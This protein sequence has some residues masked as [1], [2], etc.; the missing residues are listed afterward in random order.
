MVSSRSTCRQ[1]RQAAVSFCSWG[2][3]SSSQRAMQ[4]SQTVQQYLAASGTR[5]G[6]QVN[7]NISEKQASA[8]CMVVMSISRFSVGAL[9]S[10]KMQ[11]SQCSQVLKQADMYRSF[12]IQGYRQKKGRLENQPVQIASTNEKKLF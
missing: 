5:A 11:V 6:R 9:S 12:V 10:I 7:S 1:W 4:V 3:V 2:A 8:H